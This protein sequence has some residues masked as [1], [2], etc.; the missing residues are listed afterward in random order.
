MPR[1]QLPYPPSITPKH[2]EALFSKGS[3]LLR[4]WKET[5]P[6][7]SRLDT[8][9]SWL[10][11]PL[12]KRRQ[13]YHSHFLGTSTISTSSRC[14]TTETTRSR[15]GS[16]EVQTPASSATE[17]PSSGFFITGGGGGRKKHLPLNSVKKKEVLSAGPVSSRARGIPVRPHCGHGLPQCITD[18]NMEK[19]ESQGRR[20]NGSASVL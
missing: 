16:V 1:G 4:S 20:H 5:G 18:V 6:D 17:W 13:C 19:G 8:A 3:R 7:S 12:W 15:I 9:N 2:N 11:P 14:F 10:R